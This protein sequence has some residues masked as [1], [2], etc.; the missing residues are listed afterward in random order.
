MFTRYLYVSKVL[1]Y[2]PQNSIAFF[3]SY[4]LCFTKLKLLLLAIELKGEDGQDSKI[5]I[6]PRGA[7]IAANTQG[8]FIAQSADEVK[9]Y[10]PSDFLFHFLSTNFHFSIYWFSFA[11][12]GFTARPATRTY[13]TRRLSRNASVKTVSGSIF[14]FNSS[15]KLQSVC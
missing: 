13:E 2:Y 10:D 8:F 12:F 15:F 7:K 4:R 9:R 3:W 14:F 11:E 6:N 1:V 5:S